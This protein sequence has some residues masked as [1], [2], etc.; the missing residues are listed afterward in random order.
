MHQGT[1][2]FWTRTVYEDRFGGLAMDDEEGM[3]F[4]KLLAELPPDGEISVL[5]LANH[6]VLS[7]GR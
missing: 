4:A 3:A 1:S 2:R 5:F 7:P 6:G